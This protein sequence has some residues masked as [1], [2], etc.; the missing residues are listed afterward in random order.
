[1]VVTV[2]PTR[3]TAFFPNRSASGLEKRMPMIWTRL[4]TTKKRL[5]PTA[6]AFDPSGL[7]ESET[8]EGHLPKP[9]AGADGAEPD[10]AE[11]VMDLRLVHVIGEQVVERTATNHERGEDQQREREHNDPR[12][13]GEDGVQVGLE[14][15][16]L[17]GSGWTRSRV[18]ANVIRFRIT[19]NA[20]KMAMVMAHP[21][22]ELP[23]PNFA[24]SG[25]GG[26]E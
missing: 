24:T 15:R 21:L 12:A 11:K 2:M 19:M 22:A 18:V 5:S 17:P 26:L 4:P 20:P 6:D 3:K 7:E 14:R 8:V 23:C 16:L 13:T 25:R 9:S 1:M 10:C